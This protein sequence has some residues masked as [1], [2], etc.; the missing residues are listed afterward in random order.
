M[1]Y[2]SSL[3]APKKDL[4]QKDEQKATVT[5]VNPFSGQATGAA[6]TAPTAGRFTNVSSFLKANEGAGQRIASNVQKNIQKD[7][8]KAST[9]QASQIR[10][11]VQGESTRLAKA[12][13]FNRQVQED[14][15]KIAQDSNNLDQFRRL[16]TNQNISEAQR[17]QAEQAAQKSNAAIQQ[18][19][20]KVSALGSEQGRFNLLDQSMGRPTYSQGQRRLDQLLFQVGGAQQ[21]QQ[22]QKDLGS[23][24]GE[25]DQALRSLFNTI[26]SGVGANTKA[27]TQAEQ[28]LRGTTSGE[29]TKLTD[30]QAQ[31][32]ANLRN[33]RA[34]L[35]TALQQFFTGN[36]V[37]NQDAAAKIMDQLK[38]S[39]LKVGEKTYNTLVGD[40]YKKYLQLGKTDIT[41]LDVVDQSELDRYQALATLAN[42]QENARKFTQVGDRGPESQVLGN[43]LRTDINTQRS[44]LEKALDRELS[45]DN[46][47]AFQYGTARARGLDLLR[48]SDAGAA[49]TALVQG[50]ASPSQLSQSDYNLEANYYQTPDNAARATEA[51]RQLLSNFLNQ[52]NQAG[53]NNTLY[54]PA[55][56]RRT[57]VT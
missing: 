51:A 7:I 30:A 56:I 11:A 9:D 5:P 8:N 37:T 36:T 13:D 23:A 12:Q 54:D 50:G 53:Y 57:Q 25:R 48:Q 6:Q 49:R 34:D 31:E 18:A 2:V 33:E 47:N 17:S 26:Q 32:A 15:T 10:D 16:Y 40:N 52:I 1:A 43:L 41:D 35:N 39:D 3:Q 38:S 21:L 45:V 4:N 19:S 20:G 46:S 22:A 55:F 29:T 27:A 28:L 14:P 44:D 42:L 24:V